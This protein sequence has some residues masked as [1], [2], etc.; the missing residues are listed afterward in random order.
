[1]EKTKTEKKQKP[2]EENS[3]KRHRQD[4]AKA[5]KEIA[6]YKNLATSLE[7]MIVSAEAQLR[8]IDTRLTREDLFTT[9]PD[10]AIQLS[11]T[12]AKTADLIESLELDWLAA[13]ETYE[14]ERK[15]RGLD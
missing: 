8:T 14:K 7:M 5:L 13:L 11:Q 9:N 10:E 15:Q 4:R 1:M 12:R 2:K 6:P 3:R